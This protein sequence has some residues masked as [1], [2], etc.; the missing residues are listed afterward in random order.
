MNINNF[1]GRFP[2]SPIHRITT[3]TLIALAWSSLAC[4]SKRHSMTEIHS[5]AWQGD[6]A[7]VKALLEDNPNLV[8]SKE[9]GGETPL[10]MTV[11]NGHWDVAKLLLT[12]KADVNARNERGTTPLHLAAQ[13]G[14]TSMVELLLANMADVNV[15]DSYGYTSLYYAVQSG[16]KN[17]AELLRRHGGHE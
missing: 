17:V 3:V 4:H 16:R 15:K 7:K 8:S 14:S 2:H 1:L 5:A 10:H 9:I 11:L 13:E 12:K 6:L